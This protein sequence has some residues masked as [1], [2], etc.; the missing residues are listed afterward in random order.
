VKAFTHLQIRKVPSQYIL[1][2]YTRNARHQLM[3]DRN[4]IVTVGPDCTT[5]QFR[6]SKLVTLAMVAV[7]ACRMCRTTFEGGCQRFEEMRILTES[8][9]S[10]I[11]PS[12]Q[13]SRRANTSENEQPISAD[14]PNEAESM[15]VSMS[16]PRIAKT[17]GSKRTGK[18]IERGDASSSLNKNKKGT[19]Q[20]KTCGMY[21]R[22]YSTTC[23][24]NRDVAARG[25]GGNTGG[26]VQWEQ[27]E[28]DHQLTDNWSLSSWKLLVKIALMKRY[29]KWKI[30]T[31]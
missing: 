26:K 24:L 5:E 2:R 8:I 28:G 20:C 4:D 13:G 17:K 22:H 30:R 18:E 27:K 11:G 14:A 19:R 29:M 25:R 3:W 7:R 10:E 1:K 23:L 31:M 12:A 15:V 9:P 6:T 21:V 16:A